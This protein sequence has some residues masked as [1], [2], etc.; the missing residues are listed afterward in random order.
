MAGE[1]VCQCHDW[2]RRLSYIAF[3]VVILEVK[4]DVPN[5]GTLWLIVFGAVIETFVERHL[6]PCCLV[7]CNSYCSNTYDPFLDL[8]LEVS[9]KSTNTLAAAFNE[10]TRKETLDSENRYKCDGCKKRVCATKQLTVFRPPLSLCVQLKRFTFGGGFSLGFGG[11]GGFGG[12]GRGNKVTKPIG[13]PAEMNLPL[14]DKRSCGYGLT[15]M[16]IH[17][18]GSSSSGHYTAY[19]KKA[20]SSGSAQWYHMDDSFVEAVSEKTVLRQKDAYLLF[21]CRKEV[22]LEFP[23]PPI[24]MTAK[25]AA[26]LGRQR[27]RS[28][29]ESFSKLNK[30]EPASVHAASMAAEGK[31]PAVAVK[32]KAVPTED[33]DKKVAIA[34][35]NDGANKKVIAAEAAATAKPANSGSSSSDDSGSDSSSD[36]EEALEGKSQKNSTPISQSSALST[37]SGE[38][39]SSEVHVTKMTTLKRQGT[40]SSP[41]GD[42]SSSGSQSSSD[43][44]SDSDDDSVEDTSP[45]KLKPVDVAEPSSEKPT[46]EAGPKAKKKKKPARTRVVL[47]RGSGREKVSVMMGP[48]FKKKKTWNPQTSGTTQ[49][50]EQYELLGNRV[51]DKWADDGDAIPSAQASKISEARTNIV[52]KMEKK[53]RAQKRKAH[54]S[55]WDMSLDRGK[56]RAMFVISF[57]VIAFILFLRVSS[58]Q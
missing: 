1:T 12:K 49:R 26:E 5:A 47:D 42:S 41:G 28:R 29:S 6:I 50:G 56:V 22:K 17:V 24:S 15:G 38:S 16:V 19:V 31:P 51:I 4:L 57:N 3:L 11:F 13:F 40:D 18:G 33:L 25:E 8:A 36:E 7:G 27:A 35:K 21:Y 10:F 34:V 2:T 54:L 23:S 43:S 30:E 46:A 58:A 44:S 9:R 52:N 32:V 20:G 48:R 55:S 14:S 53:N 45:R 37:N 39:V